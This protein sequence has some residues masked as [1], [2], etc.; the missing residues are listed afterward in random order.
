MNT[1]TARQ[2]EAQT[3]ASELGNE[4][5]GHSAD[6]TNFILNDDLAD[7]ERNATWRTSFVWES[8]RFEGHVYNVRPR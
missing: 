8:G 2:T 7:E 1:T 5:L 4:I 6:W 3:I